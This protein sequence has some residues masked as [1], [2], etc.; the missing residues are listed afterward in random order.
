MTHLARDVPSLGYRVYRAWLETPAGARPASYV[1]GTAA[2]DSLVLENDCPRVTVGR[3]SGLLASV[4]DKR[5]DREALAA[6]GNGLTD[7]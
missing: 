4:L 2:G 1:S 3:R 7:R 5:A 6:P